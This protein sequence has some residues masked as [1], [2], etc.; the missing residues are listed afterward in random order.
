MP[1]RGAEKRAVDMSCEFVEMLSGG[2][3]SNPLLYKER[4]AL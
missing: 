2:T 1:F 3:S 4:S